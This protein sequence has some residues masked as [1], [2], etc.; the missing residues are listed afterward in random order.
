MNTHVVSVYRPEA[1]AAGELPH[2]FDPFDGI[3]IL[4]AGNTLEEANEI[5]D[6]YQ[7]DHP[8]WIFHIEQLR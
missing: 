4:G 8:L 6:R 5:I 2:E 1:A 7:A 3:E